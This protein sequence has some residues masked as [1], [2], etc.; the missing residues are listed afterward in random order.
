MTG[1]LQEVGMVIRIVETYPVNIPEII[2]H[3]DYLKPAEFISCVEDK[4]TA[5]LIG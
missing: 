1:I 5:V 3:I 2:I 4:V